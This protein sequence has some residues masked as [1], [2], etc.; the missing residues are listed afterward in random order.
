MGA[1]G[2][3]RGYYA[4]LELSPGASIAVVKEAFRKLAKECHPDRSHV[5]DGGARFRQISEAYEVLSNAKSKAS[6][7]AL[8]ES[9]PS[10]PPPDQ[11][12][13]Q[14]KQIEPVCCQT[15]GKVTAQPR[16]LAFWRVTSFLLASWKN[17]VQKIYCQSCA[18]REQWKSTIWT[19]LLGWWGVPWG[20]I[21]S[22][23]HGATN[24]LGG[25][26][27]V[28]VDEA[29][30]WRNAVA[31]TQSGQGTLAVGLCNILRKSENADLAHRSAELIGF[32][33]NRGV[34]VSTTLK[35]AWKRSFAQTV[36]LFALIFAVPAAAFALIFLPLNSSTS[37]PSYANA[38]PA[39]MSDAAFGNWN[40]ASG[41]NSAATS[42]PLPKPVPTCAQPPVSGAILVDNRGRLAEGHKLTIDNGSDGNAI[43]K[44][45]EAATGELV[46]SFFVHSGQ[47]ATLE[48]IPD[49]TYRIQYGF[50]GDLNAACDAFLET[51]SAD[52]FPDLETLTTEYRDDYDGTT[53]VRHELSY[54]LFDVPGGNVQP[55][56]I[57]LADFDKP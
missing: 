33:S 48:R 20:P 42:E 50:G 36:A 55:Q 10:P 31:F 38:A 23:S 34:D 9:S 44:L 7:D 28:K 40:T 3:V 22:I 39:P 51:A 41:S 2:D 21:W 52:Q 32:F 11:D 8:A 57:A 26:R 19:A 54:T 47:S 46:A 4:A 6:Y 37:G 35:D 15:C 25:T 53:V 5:T 45:R 24:A 29:L 17:P 18:I 12:A 49:G 43:I 27:D 16:R 56:T 30:M 14:Q 13:R 1:T